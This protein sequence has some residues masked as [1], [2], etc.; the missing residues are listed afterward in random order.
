MSQVNEPERTGANRSERSEATRRTGANRSEP[1]RFP[2]S[3]VQ[4]YGLHLHYANAN[5]PDTLF[6]LEAGETKNNAQILY[7]NNVKYQCVP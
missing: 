1:E 2:W 7:I 6:F 3:F 4:K 5:A